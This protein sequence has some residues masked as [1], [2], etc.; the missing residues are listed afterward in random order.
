MKEENARFKIQEERADSGITYYYLYQKNADGE[1][2]LEDLFSAG[3]DGMDRAEARIKEL[4]TPKP[5]PIVMGYY[6]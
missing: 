2:R 1:W 3:D 6:H 5:E 4:R